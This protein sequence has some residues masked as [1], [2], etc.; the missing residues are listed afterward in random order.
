MTPRHRPR[1]P[2]G[3]ASCHS[4]PE[5]YDGAVARETQ[6]SAQA[7]VGTR[8]DGKWQLDALLGFGGSATVYA[9]THRN[10]KRAA[11]KVL[12]SHCARDE[13]LVSRFLREGYL[14]NKIEHPGVV[15]VLDDSVADDGSVYL[16][17]EL[18]DGVS[19][20]RRGRGA[21]PPLEIPDVVQIGDDLLDVL[22]AAHDLGLIHRDIKPANV[23][24]TK[25]GQLKVLDFGIARLV[26]PTVESVTQTGMMMGTP[27][28]MPPEQARARWNEVDGRSDLWS[29]GATLIALFI[30]RRPR[31]A[32]TPNEELLLAMTEPLP[33]L[34]TWRPDL[35]AELVRIIDSAVMFDRAKRW[36]SARAMQSALRNFVK[37]SQL[38]S[39]TILL[40]RRALEPRPPERSL[41]GID[42][43]VVTP[44]PRVGGASTPALVPFEPNGSPLTTSRASVRSNFPGAGARGSSPAVAA[45]LVSLGI[46]LVVSGALYLK[47]RGLL[48]E[49]KH[50]ATAQAAAETARDGL[51]EAAAAEGPTPLAVSPV[52][53]LA[54]ARDAVETEAGAPAVPNAEKH[55]AKSPRRPAPVG[56][57]DPR[58]YFDSRY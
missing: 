37:A 56:S 34:A 2:P 53:T 35:P 5:C 7:R 28:F 13:A 22:A 41:P 20:D 54:A 23:F 18:L 42:S 33:S 14:A 46:A 21:D 55:D 10:G 29:V 24:I 3:T 9:A 27:A 32:E 36:Q 49:K 26:E 58:K 51:P 4:A 1:L 38:P 11:I 39:G 31:I 8:L 6:K 44:P 25:K 30:G 40:E 48:E 12:H 19:L 15:S 47:S 45:F 52:T 43:T 17:M 16:V 50:A 57:A